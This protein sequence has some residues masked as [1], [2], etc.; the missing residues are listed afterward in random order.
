MLRTA[1]I[2]FLLF[3]LPVQAQGYTFVDW[4]YGLHGRSPE[5]KRLLHVETDHYAAVVDVERA[6]IT[7]YGSVTDAPGYTAA[8]SK[9]AALFA[10]LPEIAMALR[11][12]A[13]GKTY[14][15]VRAA[16]DTSDHAVYPMRLI[17]GGRM[18]HRF[19]ILGLEF[20]TV[21]GERLEGVGRLEV[22]VWPERMWLTL[23]MPQPATLTLR[24]GDV[25]RSAEGRRLTLAYPSEGAAP[26]ELVVTDA[27]A[28]NAAC[29]TRFDALFGAT[30]VSLPARSWTMAEDLDRLDRFPVSITNTSDADQVYPVV[31]AFEDSFQGVTGLSPMLRDAEGRPTG[32]PVQISKN[33]H[34]LP[35]R[36]LLYEGAWFHGAAGI[37]VAA[38]QTWTGEFSIAY[39]RWGGVPAASHAQLSLIGWGGNQRWDQA[40]IGSFG[41]SICYDPDVGL[42]RSH[43]DDVRPLLVRG[44]ND[45]QWEWTHN[46]GGG[47][48]LVYADS[49]GTAQP[50]VGV[51][52]AY[53]SQGPN[54]TK[55]IYAGT[56][57]DGAIAARVETST[58]R[59]DDVNRVYHRIRYDVKAPAPFSRLAFYQLG[60][61][62]YNDHQ[63]TTIARGNAE[64]LA[65]AW[66]TERGGKK[67]L[68][69]AAPAEG[70]AP[71]IALLGGI[72]SPT[73]EK[74]AWADRAIVVRAWKARLGGA[75]TPLPHF[76][77]YGT[78]NGPHSANAELV[79]PPGLT[80]LIP[81]DFIE[82]EIELIVLPQS[83]GDYYGPNA[84]LKTVLAEHA[85]TW[86]LP[87]RFARKGALQIAIREGALARSLPV[88]IAVD[89]GT[90]CAACEITGGVGYVP[91]TFT[92]LKRPRGFTLRVDGEAIDQ[93]M[94]GNDYWQVVGDAD[95][96]WSVTYNLPMDGARVR[97]LVFGGL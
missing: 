81:G 20:E 90:Q 96:T 37:P 25:E 42:N 7:H 19:D 51:R 57:A 85:G 44:M 12:E 91:I 39:A 66:T 54:L 38:G 70:H 17:D 22:S 34:R 32:I 65:E 43:I 95:G 31:F 60:A 36:R 28:E 45:G 6:A 87:H 73:L 71:W 5:G 10:A 58:P 50:L 63:F 14:T 64:G 79:P 76:A 80:E 77:S 49:A 92:G 2:L 11:V 68:R 86:K 61:D 27:R 89:P 13:D 4:A 46:V 56:T 59:C 16:Q 3:A 30:V 15:C 88:E 26:P 23:A 97:G 41:E 72:R 84:A 47:N 40:A 83:A 93:S 55:V 48:F 78:E 29:P 74:G 8:A 21:E 62:N 82:A 35:E 94:H 53:V 9:D 33:W 52:T 75:D 1:S 18:L 67:Y 24:L 69:E